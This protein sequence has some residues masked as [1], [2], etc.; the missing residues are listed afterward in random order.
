M[1]DDR[2][3][4]LQY[5][6]LAERAQRY[7]YDYIHTQTAEKFTAAGETGS[8]SFADRITNGVGWSFVLGSLAGGCMGSFQGFT[9]SLQFQQTKLKLNS[10]VNFV[11]RK[12]GQY[13][14]LAG[15]VAVSYHLGRGLS[16]LVRNDDSLLDSMYGGAFAGMIFN[17]R[18]GMRGIL[19]GLILGSC[20]G[21]LYGFYCENDR[22]P[23]HKLDQIAAYL[24]SV[25]FKPKTVDKVHAD[26]PREYS[27]HDAG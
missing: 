10:M 15:C 26:F 22:L 8:R 5:K 24:N 9:H 23:K 3:L 18:R 12:G 25:Q 13:G 17:M 19:G 20:C 7:A 1:Q 11:G 6:D 21:G 16:T 27:Y 4:Q 14:N 2:A